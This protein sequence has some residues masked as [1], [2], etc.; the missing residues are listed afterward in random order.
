MMICRMV[1]AFARDEAFPN[2]MHVSYVSS[3]GV[4]A[5]AGWFQLSDCVHA[6][7]GSVETRALE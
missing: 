1:H 4:P 5:G 7:R 6:D 3:W 2:W